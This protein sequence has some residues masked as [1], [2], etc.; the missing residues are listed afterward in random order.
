MEHSGP[1]FIQ[2]SGRAKEL[3]ARE[4]VS[5]RF[6]AD[7]LRLKNYHCCFSSDT[8]L[9]ITWKPLNSAE[10]I[11]FQ[12]QQ[13]TLNSANFLLKT[14]EQRSRFLLASECRIL[15]VFQFFWL[16]PWSSKWIL[17]FCPHKEKKRTIIFLVVQSCCGLK[18]DEN[19][20]FWF[21]I[22]VKVT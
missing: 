3:A 21:A 22:I 16:I 13:S 14:A 5:E 10:N 7:Q 11:N 17:V 12:S 9:G 15:Q 2:K 19:P 18:Y 20:V 4:E 6:S 1:V 8:A